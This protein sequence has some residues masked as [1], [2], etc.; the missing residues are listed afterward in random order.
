MRPDHTLRSHIRGGVRLVRTATAR[1]RRPSR[2]SLAL[3]L[4]MV[5]VVAAIACTPS[6]P[7][8]DIR[9]WTDDMMFRISPE[10]SPPRA[11][12][13]VR[14]KVVVLDKESREPIEHG[15]G[16]IFAMNAD[17]AQTWDG[18]AKGPEPG[19]YYANLSFVTAGM[20]AIGLEFRRDS[21]RRIERMDWTQ[22]VRAATT[23]F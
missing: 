13:K 17:S 3:V 15:E 14:Y 8:N 6:A 18:L 4:T 9:Q 16:R 21:T 11:R 2:S 7:R 22:D 23:E 19:T 5:A 12:E 10:P 20:W 1:P